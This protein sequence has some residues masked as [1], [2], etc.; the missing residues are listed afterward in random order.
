[1]S[2]YVLLVYICVQTPQGSGC[3]ADIVQRW[4]QDEASCVMALSMTR[5]QAEAQAQALGHVI[6][7]DHLRCLPETMRAPLESVN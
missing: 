2:A 1:M 3:Y 5:A 7:S 6:Y 4:Y